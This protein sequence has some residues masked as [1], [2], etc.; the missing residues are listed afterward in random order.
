MQHQNK[1]PSYSIMT[2]GSILPVSIHNGEL[3]FLFGKENPTDETPGFSDFGG[4]GEKGET[5]FETA[6]REGAEET[7]FFLGNQR[8]LQKKI[9]QAG[10]FYKIIHNDY[11]VHIF[12]M[13][14][15]ENLCTYYNNNHINLW[16]NMDK[17]RLNETK[18]FEK[19]EIKWFSVHDIRK[20]KHLFRHFYKEIVDIMLHEM[21][22]IQ[23]FIQNKNKRTRT[24]KKRHR[25][26]AKKHKRRKTIKN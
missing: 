19:I 15:D 25:K 6:T 7:T 9:Q 10:G 23:M 12:P 20:K 18:L 1:N 13:E 2:A 26:I 17:K 8:D 21:P 16:K 14:Y 24:R 11:H 22:E 5:P 4:G 3:Y